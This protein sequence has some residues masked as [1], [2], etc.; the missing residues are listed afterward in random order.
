[1]TKITRL[2][3]GPQSEANGQLLHLR[4]LPEDGTPAE[5][6]GQDLRAA[7]LRRGDELG[8]VSHA[9]RIRKDYLDALEEDVPDK[10]P[11]RAYAIGFVR[12]YANYLGLDPNE[13]VARYKRTTVDSTET[14]AWIAPPAET[15]DVRF[16]G[17]WIAVAVIVAGLLAFGAYQFTRTPVSET[18][19]AVAA[20]TAVAD[21]ADPRGFSPPARHIQQSFSGAG[22]AAAVPGSATASPGQ[23]SVAP[24]S[25]MAAGQTFGAQN[26]GA[27]VVLRAHALAHVLVEGPDGKVYIN[28]LLHPG[29]VYRV[30]NVVGLS[31]TTPEGS[32][33]FLE[34][35]GQDMGAA[36]KSGRIAEALSLDPR[37]IVE[38]RDPGSD[39]TGY[40]VTQ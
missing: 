30:P 6:V 28:R 24:Q 37:A 18:P 1:M 23:A 40:K 27:R 36:G 39:G 26:R 16:G 34:L 17:T 19:A 8:R 2:G 10:L 25:S 32:A 22:V 33:V 7:R 35:D 9:L 31:L 14:G 38:R 11:G 29:D 4:D 21:H 13:Y 3:G 12:S 15:K 20:R 5:S